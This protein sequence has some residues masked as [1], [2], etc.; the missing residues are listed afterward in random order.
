MARLHVRAWPAT[1]GPLRSL[2]PVATRGTRRTRGRRATPS[3]ARA[4]RPAPG[5]RRSPTSCTG[6]RGVEHRVRA[7]LGQRHHP[8]LRERRTL[9]LV[10]P[11]PTEALVVLGGV[12]HIQT[13]SR[14]SPPAAAPPATPPASHRSPTAAR[15][16]R[17]TPSPARTPTGPGP[18]RSPTS[19]ATSP[20]PSPDRPRQP[21]GQQRQHVLI[22]ALRMQRHPDREVRHH[23]RRQR[24]M[25]L[26]GPTRLGDHLIDHT[27][28]GTSGSAPPPTP[29]PTTA[30]PT[31]ASSIQHEAP[32]QT[33]PL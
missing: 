17:T 19:T 27:P 3:P 4:G 22:G 13:R 28:A 15:P 14:R 2:R 21:V 11:G 8:G 1:T 10:H 33:T 29:D 30:A 26:L 18:G 24:P 32:T 6:R 5:Q 20:A 23:P 9:T 12:G 7:A 31:P 16:D 25:P